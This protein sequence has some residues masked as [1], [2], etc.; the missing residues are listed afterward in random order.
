MRAP[1]PPILDRRQHP[2]ATG[3]LKLF[4]L[5]LT[6]P[7]PAPVPKAEPRFDPA[8]EL[9]PAFFV[10]AEDRKLL[11]LFLLMGRLSLF[12]P[13]GG[14]FSVGVFGLRV[15]KLLFRWRRMLAFG[16]PRALWLPSRRL[17]LTRDRSDDTPLA[18]RIPVAV[19]TRW[20]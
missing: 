7:M 8:P 6:L 4:D 11:L 5:A 18:D 20:S 16:V 13:A 2:R 15:C 19:T 10:P 12:P 1:L 9:V 3:P 17:S 14:F